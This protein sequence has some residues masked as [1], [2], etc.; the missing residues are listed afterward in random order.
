MVQ[1]EAPHWTFAP[2]R[3]QVPLAWQPSVVVHAAGV[4]GTGVP[5]GQRLSLVPEVTAVHAPEVQ[6]SQGPLQARSQQRP[7]EVLPSGAQLPLRQSAP[8]PLGA[9][10][11]PFVFLQT[12]DPA[13]PGPAHAWPVAQAQ[14]SPLAHSRHTPEPAQVLHGP[15]QAALL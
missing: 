15:P 8:M 3:P 13:V 6:V 9:H 11:W 10:D 7:P 14:R 4:P 5:A 1:V 12:L 2:G